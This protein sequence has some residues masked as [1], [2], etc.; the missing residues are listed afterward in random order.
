MLHG[1]NNDVTYR[2][3]AQLAAVK[4]NTGCRGAN[5]NCVADAIAAA[6]FWL[7]SHPI[8][9]NVRANSQA[10]KQIVL[11]FNTLVDYNEGRLCAP[12]ER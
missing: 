6:D 11:T 12:H 5:S 8:G 4:L 7:C 3:G 1:S 10:W 9:S 2:L